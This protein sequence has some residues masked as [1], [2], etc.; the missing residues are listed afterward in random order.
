MDVDRET[1]DAS[2][3]RVEAI[4]PEGLDDQ[5]ANGAL[6]E[7]DAPGRVDQVGER[8]L[9]AAR[10]RAVGCR[11]DQQRIVEQYLFMNLGV[12]VAEEPAGD[13]DLDLASFQTRDVVEIKDLEPN[14]R[15]VG[16][17]SLDDA[18]DKSKRERLRATEAK[19]S[20]S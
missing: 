5:S 12:F 2:L 7:R 20:L 19:L 6:V 13:R 17:H 3:G 8:Q 9:P 11:I 16:S 4:R 1:L 18:G 10:P 15:I 14:T